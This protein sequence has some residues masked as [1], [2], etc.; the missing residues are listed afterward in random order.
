MVPEH[1]ELQ[2]IIDVCRKEQKRPIRDIKIGRS[3]CEMTPDRN[4]NHVIF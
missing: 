3:H 4:G 2:K 1:T